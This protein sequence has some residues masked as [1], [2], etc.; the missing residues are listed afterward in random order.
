MVIL[1]MIAKMKDKKDNMEITIKIKL[2]VIIVKDLD[3]MQ[4]IAEINR[5]Q[6]KIE[7]IEILN[8]MNVVKK[9]I[10]QEIVINNYEILF[11]Y[12]YNNSLKNI[13]KLLLHI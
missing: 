12:L 9:V 5:Y 13:F 1:Q 3:I 7:E 4:E 11:L 2:D 6:I 8:V 10:M